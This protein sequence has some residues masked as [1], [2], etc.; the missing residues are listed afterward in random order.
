MNVS[1]TTVNPTINQNT[2]SNNQS[3]EPAKTSRIASIGGFLTKFGASAVC[4]YIGTKII[5]EIPLNAAS[6]ALS[7]IGLVDREG[8]I[9]LNAPGM[10][11]FGAGSMV[12]FSATNKIFGDA[13]NPDGTKKGEMFDLGDVNRMAKAGRDTYL[14]LKGIEII[15]NAFSRL[16]YI[17]KKA[18]ADS[19]PL[20]TVIGAGG[21]ILLGHGIMDFA[22]NDSTETSEEGENSKKSKIKMHAGEIP[23]TAKMAKENENPSKT[24]PLIKILTGGTVVAATALNTGYKYIYPVAQSSFKLADTFPWIPLK[25]DWEWLDMGVSARASQMAIIPVQIL[26]KQI[27]GKMLYN[28]DVPEVVRKGVEV[29][30]STAT[31]IASTAI[32][33]YLGFPGVSL[34]DPYETFKNAAFWTAGAYALEKGLTFGIDKFFPD[35]N[36]TGEGQKISA[37]K[38]SKTLPPVPPSKPLSKYKS[39]KKRTSSAM[40]I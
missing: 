18:H 10:A 31:V 23:F 17:F 37:K 19:L 8:W 30:A 9:Y 21:V 39:P 3:T 29:A 1:D 35:E 28:P 33:S 34:S 7:I 26:A 15:V 13:I 32:A 12:V 6:K 24:V 14:G 5:G 38:L 20:H 4:G 36:G 11:A 25:P 16:T 22:N 27:F 2:N 40:V